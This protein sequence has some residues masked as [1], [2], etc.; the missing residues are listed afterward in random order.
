LPGPLEQT[1]VIDIGCAS[2]LREAESRGWALARRFGNSWTHQSPRSPEY[3]RPDHPGTGALIPRRGVDLDEQR[4]CA[5]KLIES[6]YSNENHS[7][8]RSSPQRRS[9]VVP[10]S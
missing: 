7:E 8:V 9:T 4:V 1:G 6:A 2:S 3:H 5:P 10:S